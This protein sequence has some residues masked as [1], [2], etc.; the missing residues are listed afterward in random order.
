M[1]NAWAFIISG[2]L[3]GGT[4]A[5][6]T[7]ACPCNQTEKSAKQAE[8]GADNTGKGNGDTDTGGQNT[9]NAMD[10]LNAEQ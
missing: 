8:Q 7:Y 1:N 3:L 4:F 6:S 9:S 5:S 10:V 2:V